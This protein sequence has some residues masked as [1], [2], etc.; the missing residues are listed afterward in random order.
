MSFKFKHVYVRVVSKCLDRLDSAGGSGGVRHHY[1]REI[2]TKDLAK[3]WDNAQLIAVAPTRTVIVYTHD[4]SGDNPQ[5]VTVNTPD[6]R[7]VYGQ[8]LFEAVATLHPEKDMRD[9]KIVALD[10]TSTEVSMYDVWV[11]LTCEAFTMTHRSLVRDS[12]DMLC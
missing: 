9:L 3:P 7:Y 6:P 12:S 11:P 4:D 8:D 1:A 5:E 2:T 10:D